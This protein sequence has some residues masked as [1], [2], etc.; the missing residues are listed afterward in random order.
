MVSIIKRLRILHLTINMPLGS[1]SDVIRQH[2]FKSHSTLTAILLLSN[3]EIRKKKLLPLVV[4]RLST[5]GNQFGAF[6]TLDAWRRHVT[7][8]ILIICHVGFVRKWR[9]VSYWKVELVRSESE[10]THNRYW[11]EAEDSVCDACIASYLRL[12]LSYRRGGNL[13]G[14]TLCI[15]QIC[16]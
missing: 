13:C 9:M 1:R 3:F 10:F 4:I 2:P 12:S 6:E 15:I 8:W 16:L 5:F 7:F 11:N 14:I